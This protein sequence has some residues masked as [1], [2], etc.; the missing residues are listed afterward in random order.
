[1]NVFSNKLTSRRYLSYYVAISLYYRYIAILRK[2]IKNASTLCFNGAKLTYSV[3]Q[4]SHKYSQKCTVWHIKF[5]KFPGG[6]NRTP[7]AGGATPSA[8]PHQDGLRPCAGPQAAPFVAPPQM[9]NTNRRPWMQNQCLNCRG[10]E[11]LNPAPQ[12]FAQSPI[13][14]K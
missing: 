13:K 1:M 11:G 5:P 4:L 10:V 6:N 12:L 7:I 8:R 14:Y 9:L 3:D 2:L